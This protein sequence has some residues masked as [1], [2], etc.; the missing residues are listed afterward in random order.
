MP[1]P[2]DD[3][4]LSVREI[5]AATANGALPSLAERL[6]RERSWFALIS[7]F[8]QASSMATPVPLAILTETVRRC[9]IALRASP[10]RRRD[11]AG[12]GDELRTV[13]LAAAEALLARIPRPTLTEGDRLALRRAAALLAEGGDLLRAAP[14]FE[15]AHDWSAAAEVWGRLGELDEMEACLARDEDRRRSQRAAIGAVRDIEALAAAGERV[16]ALR[17]A[18][19]IPE[20]V[21]ESAA[22]R[23]V[24]L[25]LG[26][27]LVRARSVTFRIADD[28][29]SR[30]FRFAATPAVLGRDPLAEIPLR[31]PGVSRRHA[32]IAVVG[33]EASLTDAGSRAGTF[34]AGARLSTAFPLRGDTEVTLGPSC[35]LELRLPAPGR[36]LLRGASGLDRGLLAALGSGALPLDDLIPEAAGAWLEF[37]RTGARFCRPPELQVRIAGQLVS[38]RVDLLHGDTLQ[39]G[40]GLA[41]LEVE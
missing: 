26:A 3:R 22:A 13:R 36:L 41:R 24:I 10:E 34:V 11:R 19:G 18:E 33:E 5:K 4:S 12:A 16:A 31:D 20:G 38:R 28:R 39:I 14:A 6:A 37:D 2:E 7:L 40:S 32:L 15:Q 25:G 8:E 35:R 30:S 17:V 9:S 21:A 1:A 23:Q 27:R 29:A